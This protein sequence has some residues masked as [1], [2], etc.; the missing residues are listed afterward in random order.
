MAKDRFEDALAKLEAIVKQMEGGDMPLEESIK[1]FE[2]GIR[3]VQQCTEK[4]NDAQ[5]RVEVLLKADGAPEVAPFL[6]NDRGCD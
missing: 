6:E 1:A 5:R 2:Q 3:L 4:L